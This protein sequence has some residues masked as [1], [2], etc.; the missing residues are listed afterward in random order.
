MVK[1]VDRSV[2]GLDICQIFSQVWVKLT[3]PFDS[4]TDPIAPKNLMSRGNGLCSRDG[5]KP[6]NPRMKPHYYSKYRETMK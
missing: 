4:L 2:R 3:A 5:D 6:C 1:G